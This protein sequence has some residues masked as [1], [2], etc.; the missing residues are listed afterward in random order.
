MLQN[1]WQ[2]KQS[3]FSTVLRKMEDIL[4]IER[5]NKN[6]ESSQGFYKKEFALISSILFSMIFYVSGTFEAP[7]HLE[8]DIY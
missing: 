4:K 3:R 5:N 7:C 6:F 1:V 8:R 2:N